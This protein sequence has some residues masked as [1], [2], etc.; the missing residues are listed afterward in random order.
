MTDT[1]RPRSIK[2]YA[3]RLQPYWDLKSAVVIIG[4]KLR[5]YGI[6]L[7]RWE[8]RFLADQALP[9]LIDFVFLKATQDT[10]WKDP[11]F[12]QLYLDIQS[13][14]VKGAYH[15][16]SSAFG[17]VPQAQ[18]FLRT[19]G[20]KKLQVL[21][22]D[23]ETIGN[24]MSDKFV[25]ALYEWL[26]YVSEQRPDCRVI[27]YTN[28]NIYDNVLH[29][30][31]MRIWGRDVF[32]EWELWIAQYFWVVNPDGQPIFKRRSSWTFWQIS[33]AGDPKE[34]GTQGWCDRNVFNGSREELLAWAKVDGFEPEPPPDGGNMKAKVLQFINLRPG[35]GDLSADLGDL[36]K[37]DQI[38]YSEK[39]NVTSGSYQGY[40]YHITMVIRALDGKTIFAPA[41]WWCWGKYIEEVPETTPT[42]TPSEKPKIEI[43]YDASKVD[44]VL[45]AQ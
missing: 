12:E 13:I 34:H 15:Y 14:A 19:I 27:F 18:H 37:G 7:S 2:F 28:P 29:P 33:D 9:G 17:G 44:V 32:L 8:P 4:E 10:I 23:F 41:N 35:A 36:L 16:L 6:D 3:H 38:E 31:A 24:T 1:R 11:A 39:K 30:A 25:I 20:T 43:V 42:P 40:W 45:K 22:V 26:V 21:I 5:A